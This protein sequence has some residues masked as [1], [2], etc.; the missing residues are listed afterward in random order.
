MDGWRDRKELKKKEREIILVG[1]EFFDECLVKKA[2][3]VLKS[4]KEKRQSKK[5]LQSI[6]SELHQIKQTQNLHK[7]LVLWYDLTVEQVQSDQRFDQIIH[8]F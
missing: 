4:Y 3:G 7:C 6:G 5:Q 8:H 1:K 2:F